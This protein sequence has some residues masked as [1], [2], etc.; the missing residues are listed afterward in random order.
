MKKDLEIN[1]FGDI[2]DHFANLFYAIYLS[3]EFA[4]ELQIQSWENEGGRCDSSAS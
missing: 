3:Y 1:N 4:F 2:V